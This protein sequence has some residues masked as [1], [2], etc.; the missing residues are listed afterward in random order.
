MSRN[1]KSIARKFFKW[2]DFYSKFQSV[3]EKQTGFKEST[4]V[5]LKRKNMSS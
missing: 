3:L 4:N 2:K 5:A 1:E